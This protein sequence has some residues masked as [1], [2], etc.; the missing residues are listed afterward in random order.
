MYHGDIHKG[1]LFTRMD[2]RLYTADND[3]V[4]IRT[5]HFSQFICT[6][7]ENSCKGQLRALIFGSVFPFEN[8]HKSV[9]RVHVGSSLFSIKDFQYVKKVRQCR[10]SDLLS[11]Y[12]CACDNL[13]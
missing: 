8:E 11:V 4:Y 1:T 5:K 7:C 13:L 9:V 6:S 3:F 2:P 10:M 12:S